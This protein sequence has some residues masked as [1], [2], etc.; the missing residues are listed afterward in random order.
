[1]TN[2]TQVDKLHVNA[3]TVVNIEGQSISNKVVYE[4]G[5]LRFVT[6]YVPSTE[7]NMASTQHKVVVLTDQGAYSMGESALAE[8]SAI[9]RGD[10]EQGVYDTAEYPLLEVEGVTL[11]VKSYTTE[12]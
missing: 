10:L 3:I 4:E 6:E 2:S 12:D 1:M 7:K 5:E 11:L 8:L 9:V